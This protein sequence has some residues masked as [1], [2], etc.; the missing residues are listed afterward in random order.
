MFEALNSCQNMLKVLQ[1]FEG[2]IKNM[3]HKDLTLPGGEGGGMEVKVKIFLNGDF[4]MLDLVMGH[5]T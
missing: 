4:K 1:P 2:P 3:Q 5:Q